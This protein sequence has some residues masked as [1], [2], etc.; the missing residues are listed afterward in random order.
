MAI[1]RRDDPYRLV[2]SMTGVQ[3]ADRIAQV[4]CP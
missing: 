1:L 4:G 2:V 3:M